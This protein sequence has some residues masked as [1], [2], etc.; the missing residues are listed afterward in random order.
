[1]SDLAQFS[2]LGI[3][4]M[5]GFKSL[6]Q[7]ELDDDSSCNDDDYFIIA[8]TGIVQTW[9]FCS[10]T[11]C[12]LSRST[13]RASKDVSRLFGGQSDIRSTFISSKVGVY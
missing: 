1:L 10:W 7:M 3:D 4:I 2:F 9:W 5:I 8:A 6:L 12:Y 11:C 13:R